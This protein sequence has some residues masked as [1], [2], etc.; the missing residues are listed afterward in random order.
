MSAIVYQSIRLTAGILHPAYSSYKAM[1][2]KNVKEYV[3]WM[4]YWIVF[5]IFTFVESFADIL[6]AWLPFYY[7]LKILFLVWLL[8]PAT[9]GASVLYRKVIHPNMIKNEK[10]IDG[11]VA[12]ASDQCYAALIALGSRGF[13]FATNM[14]LTTA[15]KGQTKLADHL[16]KSFSLSD[17]SGDGGEVQIFQRQDSNCLEE[18]ELD[19][20]LI[21]EQYRREMAEME[22]LD[23][24]DDAVDQL[25]VLKLRHL[26]RDPSRSMDEGPTLAQSLVTSSVRLP[27]KYTHITKEELSLSSNRTQIT[28][29]VFSEKAEEKETV[30]RSRPFPSPSVTTRGAPIAPS[31]GIDSPKT[32]SRFFRST[33]EDTSSTAASSGPESWR[34]RLTYSKWK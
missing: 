23:E 2:G 17:L 15:I 12:K 18:D 20:K 8:L 27:R 4:M 19:N 1:R 5:A 7:E 14:V 28:T 32:I 31:E 34:S 9:K 30:V 3:K 33:S 13:S 16:K 10:E 11:Y 24:V 22:K 26:N 6:L 25:P 29:S 21:T